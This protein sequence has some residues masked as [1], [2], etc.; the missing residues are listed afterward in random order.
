MFKKRLIFLI[1]LVFLISACSETKKAPENAA[2]FRNWQ[3]DQSSQIDE[4]RIAFIPKGAYI[5]NIKDDKAYPVGS[6]I[7]LTPGELWPP[8]EPGPTLLIGRIAERQKNTARIEILAFQ[9]G[10]REI[11]PHF[12]VYSAQPDMAHFLHAITKRLTFATGTSAQDFVLTPMTLDSLIQGNEIYGAF[13]LSSAKQGARLA[14]ANTA[15]MT[16]EQVSNDAV[17]LVKS[18]GNIPD[19]PG[20]V[21]LD[22]PLPPAFKVQIEIG[23]ISNQKAVSEQMEK[24]LNQS[25]PGSEF[26]RVSLKSLPNEIDE[27]IQSLGQTQTETLSIVLNE[28]HSK[29]MLIDQGL[30]LSDAPWTVVISEKS[31]EIEALSAV[32]RAFE[33]AGYPASAA[34]LLETAWT[35]A[36]T[37]QERAAITPAL[38]S[39]YHI[40]ERDDWGLEVGL[41]MLELSKKGSKK[42][43]HEMKTAAVAAL[44]ISGRASEFSDAVDEVHGFISSMDAS[45]KKVFAHAMLLSQELP[46]WHEYFSSVRKDWNEHDEMLECLQSEDVE[47]CQAGIDK[48]QTPFGRLWF[49]T[50]MMS[51]S[52]PSNKHLE[53]ASQIDAIG[54]PNLAIHLWMNM[55]SSGLTGEAAASAW[56]NM[57]QYARLAQQTRTYLRMMSVYAQHISG[58]TKELSGA[59]SGWKSLDW[60]PEIASSCV[61]HAEKVPSGEA[62]DL[63]LF[64]TELYLSVGDAENA[65]ILY[66]KLAKAYEQIGQQEKADYYR[67][68][69]KSFARGTH[70]KEVLKALEGDVIHAEQ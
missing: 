30:R 28:Y 14:N 46:K 26:I 41:E 59:L 18:T 31:D 11:R 32:V 63:L 23:N 37:V 62:I 34:F 45:W 67:L 60:R 68:N 51:F 7:R 43:Q 27:T 22:A 52:A 47:V 35:K 17:K 66:S 25:L 16:T 15:I 53:L 13:D 44:A 36:K 49:Q 12:E 40:L 4:M 57:A 29:P 64:A 61:E 2:R 21:L 10:M 54:A 3:F 58:D 48:S 8:E 70:H 19:S 65:A 24:L 55:I 38:A 69:A 5:I 6:W 20:F 42:E 33:M 1:V 50:M 56:L 9:P 39:I